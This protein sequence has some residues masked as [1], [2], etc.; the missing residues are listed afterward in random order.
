MAVKVSSL[1][2]ARVGGG[3]NQYIATWGAPSGNVAASYR[4]SRYAGVAAHQKKASSATEGYAYHWSYTVYTTAGKTKTVVGSTSTTT[5]RSQTFDAPDNALTVYFYVRPA[6]KKYTYYPKY[7]ETATKK[8]NWFSGATA[9]RSISTGAKVP[10]TPSISNVSLD[11]GVITVKMASTGAAEYIEKYVLGIYRDNVLVENRTIKQTGETAT[12]AWRPAVAGAA[13]SFTVYVINERGRKSKASARSTPVVTAPAAPQAP[14]VAAITVADGSGGA[15]RAKVTWNAVKGATAYTVAMAASDSA[16]NAALLPSDAWT[17]AEA[18]T[19]AAI[20]SPQSGTKTFF[21]VKASNPSGESAWS[22]I[23]ASPFIAGTKPNPPT[24][25]ASA[26]AVVNTG[27]A[28]ANWV[29]NSE[30]ESAQTAA[31]VMVGTSV[32]DLTAQTRYQLPVLNAADGSTVTFKVRTQGIAS[33]GWSDWSETVSVR[34][35]HLPTLAVSVDDTVSAFPFSV[36]VDPAAANQYPVV[37]DLEIEATADHTVTNPDGTQRAVAAGEVIYRVHDI[38]P[39]DPDVITFGAG[40]IGLADA[41]E[42]VARATVSMSSGLSCSNSASFTYDIDQTDVC[43]GAQL[44]DMGDYSVQIAPYAIEVTEAAE[45][46]GD[47][48]TSEEGV[49]YVETMGLAVYRIE[50]DGTLTALAKNMGN[51]G[52]YSIVDPHATF[53]SQSYRIV[54]I[55]SVTGLV[56]FEDVYDE[57]VHSET[58]CFSWSSEAL[59]EDGDDVADPETVLELPY[60]IRINEQYAPDAEGVAFIGSKHPEGAYGTQLGATAKW[61]AV[62]EKDDRGTVARLRELA[63]LMR[64][65]YV[66]EPMGNGFWAIVK[67]SFSSEAADPFV[68]AEFDITRVNRKDECLVM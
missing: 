5:T 65:V 29:H 21:R 67:V 36:T 14:S 23:T 22:A 26:D 38:T 17:T 39:A 41:Q 46:L 30:D 49:S 55:D 35:W 32:I 57:L 56:A 15:V 9:S 7:G 53:G 43:I 10:D 48:E 31:Q 27:E 11:G 68:T 24:V 51:D 37:V 33:A 45:G 4:G 6:A 66:R 18:L 8:A 63:T 2:L 58:I 62:F 64:D 34:V 42:Y 25:W 47:D 50:T 1:S 52:T 54:A 19:S 60:N 59:V 40:D 16:A 44:T 61:S 20:M 3:T 28:Y 12:Y 13:Y